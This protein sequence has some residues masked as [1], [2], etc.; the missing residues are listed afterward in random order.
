[1]E[2]NEEIETLKARVKEGNEKLN[3]AWEEICKIDHSSQRWKDEVERWHQ[4]NLDLSGK[5]TELKALGYEDCLYM[6]NGVR[7][8]TCLTE[9]A[10][11]C[12]VCPS[13]FPYWE[14]EFMELGR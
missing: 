12:R 2:K 8:K 13:L 14:K 11:G 9:G 7:T 10:L 3:R 4:A 1:M 6:E 5:C